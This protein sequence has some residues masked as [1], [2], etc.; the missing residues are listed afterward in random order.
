[1]FEGR[2]AVAGAV[3]RVVAM[4]GIVVGTVL[5]VGPMAFISFRSCLASMTPGLV[6]FVTGLVAATCSLMAASGSPTGGTLAPSFLSQVAD[7][8]GIVAIC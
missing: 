5:M 7:L 1:M 6:V 4:L 2:P 3:V 8:G